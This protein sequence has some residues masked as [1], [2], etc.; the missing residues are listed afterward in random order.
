MVSPTDSKHLVVGSKN[1]IMV[2]A[3]WGE[4]HTRM[5]LDACLPSLTS[6][7][8]I[9]AF[10]KRHNCIARIYTRRRERAMIED[11]P[12]FK[13]LSKHIRIEVDSVLLDD[14]EGSDATK[15]HVAWMQ[16]VDE[17][18]QSNMYVWNMLPDVVFADNS[19]GHLA[20]LL[21][22]GYHSVMWFYPRVVSHTFVPDYLR[23]LS[24]MPDK[25]VPSRPLVRLALKHFHPTM[26]AYFI[27]SPYFPKH[28]ELLMTAVKGHGIATR[29][30]INIHNI[31]DPRQYMLSEQNLTIGNFNPEHI[32]FIT[33]SDDFFAVSLAP[34][35]KDSGWYRHSRPQNIIETAIWW[36]SFDGSAND[37]ISSQ[38]IRIHMDD[39]DEQAWVRSS[40]SLSVQIRKTAVIREAIRLFD[41]LEQRLLFDVTAILSVCIADGSLFRAVGRSN[42]FLILIPNN[43]TAQ[44]RIAEP[45]GLSRKSILTQRLKRHLVDIPDGQD[46]LTIDDLRG[47]TL[48]N[49]LGDE[50]KFEFSNRDDLTVNGISAGRTVEHLFHQRLIFIESELH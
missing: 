38:N 2:I 11:C 16:V 37:Y 29:M 10:A 43:V 45:Q 47:R 23:T 22:A 8:N 17:A 5:L 48:K 3:V 28:S 31:Y 50:L 34:L 19:I 25:S 41:F 7:G 49:L 20:E 15:H 6:P 40:H 9:P 12:A 27:D 18:V 30:L 1:V 36:L 35:G 44:N 4:W 13:E 14:V 32:H 46:I 21:H 24:E 26:A 33:D 42:K 39:I